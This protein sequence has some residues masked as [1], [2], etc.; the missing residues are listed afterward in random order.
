MVSEITAS[1]GTA[2]AR[3]TWL[4]QPLGRQVALP[5]GGDYLVEQSWDASNSSSNGDCW[6]SYDIGGTARLT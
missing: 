6:V 1:E 5:R 4:W 2:S 3:S